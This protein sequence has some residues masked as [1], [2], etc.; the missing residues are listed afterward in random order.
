MA[1]R[2]RSRIQVNNHL[3]TVSRAHSYSIPLI[4][5]SSTVCSR[6]LQVESH[7]RI[8]SNIELHTFR[9]ANCSSYTVRIRKTQSFDIFIRSNDETELTIRSRYECCRFAKI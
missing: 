3:N 1:G 4:A 9:I 7:A 5:A 2:I 6:P 8:T